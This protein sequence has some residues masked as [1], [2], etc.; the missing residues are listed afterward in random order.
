VLDP[1][2]GR[3][4]TGRLWVYTRDDRSW[5]GPDPPAAVYFYSF[6]F[7]LQFLVLPRAAD[8]LE[9]SADPA[10][11]SDWSSRPYLTG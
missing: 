8:H 5:S 9:Q 10:R 1:G 6:W 2:R 4:K 11:P 3:T 7:F